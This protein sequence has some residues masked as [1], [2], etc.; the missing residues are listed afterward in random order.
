MVCLLYK[1]TWT[2]HQLFQGGVFVHGCW[3][4]R[5]MWQSEGCERSIG[6]E[7][8]WFLY[9][10]TENLILNEMRDSLLDME[11]ADP[12]GK[13]FEPLSPPSAWCGRAWT[14]HP[15]HPVSGVWGVIQGV[16][17]LPLSQGHTGGSVPIFFSL[18][19]VIALAWLPFFFFL[20]LG[21]IYRPGFDCEDNCFLVS[22]CHSRGNKK[23]PWYFELCS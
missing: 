16:L 12:W 23:Y 4:A 15:V 1:G 21:R 5:L 6:N 17:S 9:I 19:A 13:R 3:L 18:M 2:T 22:C 7:L 20:S 11:I 10:D 14:L 8:T